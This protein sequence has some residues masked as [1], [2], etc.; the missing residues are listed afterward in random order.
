MGCGKNENFYFA[1]RKDSGKCVHISEMLEKDRGLACN[2]ICAA[3]GR[4]LAAKLGRGKRIR[5]F[6]HV[7]NRDSQPITDCSSS[8][9]NESGLHKLAKEIICESSYIHLPEIVI[10]ARRDE[11]RNREDSEQQKPYVLSQKGK[12]R[13]KAVHAE[14]PHDGFVPDICIEWERG[15]LLV[16]IAVTHYVD[17]NKYDKIKRAGLP[18]IEIDI[19]DFLKKP[20][21]FSKDELRTA[22]IDSVEHKKWIYH[23]REQEGIEKLCKRNRD[24]EKQ[25]QVERERERRKQEQREEWIEQQKKHE[26]QTANEFERLQKDERYYLECSQQLVA[27]GQVLN[28]INR[29][30]I[31]DLRFEKEEDLPF[32]LNIPVFGEVAFNC[33]RRI[34]QTL[35]FEKFIYYRR[36]ESTIQTTKVYFYFAK[37]KNNLLNP[38][39]VHYRK[40]DFP[41]NDILR[42]AIE[43]YLVH[44]SGLGF[45]DKEFYNWPDPDREYEILT[46]TIEPKEKQYAVCIEQA[47]AKMPRTNDPFGYLQK[48]WI[49]EYNKKLSCG[50]IL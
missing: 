29:L 23:R 33:D 1:I 24:R 26:K 49:Q 40:N 43:E 11:Q 10:N 31:C 7:P 28:C 27:D 50:D 6:S 35:L 22:L 12:L 4:P 47:I 15:K 41:E 46:H 17:K 8:K 37:Y 5:H 42:C 39:F 3:C 13:C 38:K 9:A 14:V 18:A 34:W 48:E 44:L 36:E 16:E 45:I 20:E 25:Y 19:S 32:F 30:G 21:E 2:C